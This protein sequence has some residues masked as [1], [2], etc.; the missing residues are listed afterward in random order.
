M[1]DPLPPKKEKNSRWGF[2]KRWRCGN[3]VFVPSTTST[4]RVNVFCVVHVMN[5]SYL[6]GHNGDVLCFR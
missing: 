6:V 3:A 2:E 1:K 4:P 5:V